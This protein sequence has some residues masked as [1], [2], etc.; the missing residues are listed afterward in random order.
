MNVINHVILKNIEKS[1]IDKLVEECIENI[2]EK[3]LHLSEMIYN[4][5]LNAYEKLFS[6][7][8]LCIVVCY[9]FHNKYKH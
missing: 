5:I 2:N 8:T 6:S 7:C 1:L 4:S 3:K 9:I